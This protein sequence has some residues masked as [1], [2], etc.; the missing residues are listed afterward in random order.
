MNGQQLQ[1]SMKHSQ[2]M[3]LFSKFFCVSTQSNTLPA[4]KNR[5]A[6]V[7]DYRCS[8]SS[9][10]LFFDDREVLEAL[11]NSTLT[12]VCVCIPT[13]SHVIACEPPWMH[14]QR[15]STWVQT[16]HPNPPPPPAYEHI[17]QCIHKIIRYTASFGSSFWWFLYLCVHT[18]YMSSV[19]LHLYM[20]I[21]HI[22]S[23]ECKLWASQ[24]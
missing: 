3:S 5:A 2:M 10:V 21:Y 14:G 24:W 6:L 4:T 1:Q 22:P 17:L 13:P 15:T 20:S 18:L 23:H 7:M 16:V 8:L 11:A 12:R 9:A 19:R